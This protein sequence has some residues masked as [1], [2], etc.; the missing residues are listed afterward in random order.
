MSKES[1]EN[2]I[3]VIIVIVVVVV[4]VWRHFG[5]TILNKLSNLNSSLSYGINRLRADV[6]D[7]LFNKG[8]RKNVNKKRVYQPPHQQ[9]PTYHQTYTPSPPQYPKME[10]LTPPPNYPQYPKVVGDDD[11]EENPYLDFDE[12]KTE[13]KITSDNEYL[14][15]NGDVYIDYDKN[16]AKNIT[17]PSPP[18]P[19]REQHAATLIKLPNKDNSTDIDIYID[20]LSGTI[21]ARRILGQLIATCEKD[22]NSGDVSTIIIKR[23]NGN[24]FERY[25]SRESSLLSITPI[26]EIHLYCENNR[27]VRG[28]LYSR[29]F[30]NGTTPIE[31]FNSVKVRFEVEED[32]E[33]LKL[34]Y[35]Y[36]N[37]TSGRMA[38]IL[39]IK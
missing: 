7:I 15:E 26:S 30:K 29:A 20:E 1:V 38:P 19:S 28:S 5:N 27:V 39:Y 10:D 11:E 25:P 23:K 35:I 17:Q 8:R 13:N 36:P 31:G 37:S 12:G 6:K 21:M 18:Q 16:E 14:D 22:E 34:Y 9:Q 4:L 3:I 32:S 33:H 2:V 24:S